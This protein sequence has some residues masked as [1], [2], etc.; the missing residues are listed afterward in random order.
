MK[1][2]V[3]KF[4]FICILSILNLEKCISIENPS[5]LPFVVTAQKSGEL[6]F[7]DLHTQSSQR[8]LFIDAAFGGLPSMVYR[9]ASP[10][11]LYVNRTVMSLQVPQ[12][13]V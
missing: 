11:R 4:N 9:S 13:K 5:L 8:E 7:T 6:L 12:Q 10:P 1:Y 3:L 2:N